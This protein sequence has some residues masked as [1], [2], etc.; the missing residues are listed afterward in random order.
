MTNSKLKKRTLLYLACGPYKKEN[1][2]LPYEMLIVAD[3]TQSS[4]I[5]Y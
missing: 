4:I 1:K 3:K 5:K 2:A